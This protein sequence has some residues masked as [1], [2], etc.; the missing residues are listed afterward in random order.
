MYGNEKFGIRRVINGILEYRNTPYIVLIAI[1]VFLLFP[2]YWSFITSIKTTQEIYSWPPTLFPVDPSLSGYEFSLLTAPV[3]TYILNS[4]I[5]S[6]SASI[7]VTLS[8][9][10]TIYGLT[11]FPF[12]G[13]RKILFSFFA[14]RLIPPQALWLPFVIMYSKIGL[15]NTRPGVVIFIVAIIY[16]LCVWMLKS[17]FEAFPK[18]L[19][20]AASIDGCSRMKILYKIAVPILAPGISAIAIISF[21]WAWAEFMFPFIILND[22]SLHPITVG[23]YFFIGE[24]GILWN[25]LSA[26]QILAIT[27]GLIFFII[28]QK[29]IIKGLSAGAVKG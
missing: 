9:T 22:Q 10:V 17:L 14:T 15:I 8:A 21:L 1:F 27:P 24:E 5:Y 26:T 29:H 18:E 4:V 19:I 16:P 3:P 11:Q 7:I 23:V 20:D 2:F 28:A 13:S 6:L 25:A 12:R